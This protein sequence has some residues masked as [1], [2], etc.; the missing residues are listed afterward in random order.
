M[1]GNFGKGLFWGFVL[2]SVAGVAAGV[3]LAPRSGKE[4]RSTIAN[5]INQ[6]LE[7]DQNENQEDG[8]FQNIE[9]EGKKLS[10]AL[11]EDARE[12]A[13]VLLA[14]ADK[15]LNEIRSKSSR[16]MAESPAA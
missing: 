15:L 16:T 1:N 9:N 14:D 11:I 2:G 7:K 4:V 10:E 12:K 8:F 5:K 6:F 3:L 13:E